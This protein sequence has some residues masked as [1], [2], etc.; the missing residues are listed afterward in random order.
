[1][2][3]EK[4]KILKRKKQEEENHDE[5]DAVSNLQIDKSSVLARIKDKNYD[6]SLHFSKRFSMDLGKSAK[7]KSFLV[8]SGRNKDQEQVL[9]IYMAFH[10][11]QIYQYNIIATLNK[12]EVVEPELKQIYGE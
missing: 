4:R 7:A 9:R 12:G 3:Q 5:N 6:M 8:G 10:S 2:R 11:N 1:M